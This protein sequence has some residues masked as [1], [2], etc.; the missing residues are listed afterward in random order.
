[1]LFRSFQIAIAYASAK[2]LNYCL[3]FKH[4]Q[5][6]GCRQGKHPST[7]YNNIF[8]KIN[9]TDIPDSD[10][11]IIE[12]SWSAY[13]VMNQVQYMMSDSI[14]KCVCFKGYYQSYNNWKDYAQ[15]I[16][17]LFTPEGGIIEY[18]KNNSDIFK[19]F[20]ELAKDNDYVFMGIRRGDYI[21]YPDT[22]NPCGMTYY[23]DAINRMNKKDQ[24][25]YIL[26]DDWNWAK[27]KFQGNNYKFLELKEDK[28]MLLTM[29]LF[30]NYII[31]NS[32]FYWWGSF[33]S[34]YKNVKVIAPDKWIFK[35]SK[36]E[37]YWS[38]Y[39]EKMDILERPIETT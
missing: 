11:I 21:T 34:I 26:T 36:K 37:Q 24:T 13:H 10:C 16:K 7:Y 35:N 6:G 15:E 3:K 1:M 19:T 33:L 20:P 18:L 30:K 17:E 39:R 38:V 29:T 9:F 23:T 8:Q 31:S 27:S 5:F 12:Q 14:K 2:R 28:I 25:C 22:H 4:N 32:S